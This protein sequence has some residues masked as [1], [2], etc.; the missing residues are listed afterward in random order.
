MPGMSFER[1]QQHPHTMIEQEGEH[2]LKDHLFHGLRSNIQNV[3]YYMY[4]KSDS[5]YSKLVIAARKA[6]TEM[7]GGGI[8]EA[9][10]KSAVVELDTQAE[11]NSSKSPHE[12][13][14]MQ[15]I[16]YPHICYY[17]PK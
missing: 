11:A 2:H 6:E 8:S 7:P 14:I 10:A 13:A 1:N 5:Q 3:L 9:R 16:V 12:E 4:D 15:Q 17:K